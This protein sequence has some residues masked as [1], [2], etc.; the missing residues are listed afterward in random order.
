MVRA[1]TAGPV[2]APPPAEE[3]PEAETDPAAEPVPEETEVAAADESAVNDALAEAL[4]AEQPVAAANS[5]P[6]M[7]DT[8]MHGMRVAVSRCWN[9]G[10][11]SSDALRT[12]VIV[13]VAMN[14]DGRPG[15]ISMQGFEGGSESSANQAFEAARR[16]I[17]RCGTEGFPLP[18]EKYEQW[19]EIEMTFDPSEMR[20]R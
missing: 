10:S 15:A 3:V 1:R 11:L 16:A 8:E 12:K 13:L 5:G 2:Y 19:R 18:A 14:A 4:A 6:P 17:I 7:T 20:I 9:V